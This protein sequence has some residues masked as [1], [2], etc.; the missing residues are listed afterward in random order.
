MSILVQVRFRYSLHIATSDFFLIRVYMLSLIQFMNIIRGHF[1]VA[2]HMCNNW[3]DFMKWKKLKYKIMILW[4]SYSLCSIKCNSD[5]WTYD[6]SKFKM[7]LPTP[8]PCVHS[9][10]SI[11]NSSIEFHNFH[12]KCKIHDIVYTKNQL[13]IYE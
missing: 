7:F 5:T 10:F 11:W 12:L 2:L 8:F 9:D 13:K 1:G 6:Y 3:F 4:F